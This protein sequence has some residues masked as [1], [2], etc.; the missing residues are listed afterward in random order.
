M[1]VFYLK[2]RDTLPVLVVTLRNPDGTVHNLTGATEAKLNILL[3][4][5]RLVTRDMAIDPVPT[6]GIVRYQWVAADDWVA[7]GLV[8]GEHLMEYEVLGVGD[9][10]L[11]FPNGAHHRLVVTRD[12]GQGS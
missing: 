5:G 3:S 2:Y 4:N 12:I 11:T 10:R 6:T 8:P 7:G 1:N 9:A